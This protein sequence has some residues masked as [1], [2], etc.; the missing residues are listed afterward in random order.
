MAP[1]APFHSSASRALR[2]CTIAAHWWRS[3]FQAKIVTSKR[4]TVSYVSCGT[5]LRATLLLRAPSGKQAVARE[6]PIGTSAPLVCRVPESLLI[7]H[8]TQRDNLRKFP[9]LRLRI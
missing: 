1:G 5:Q 2:C 7:I 9:E 4:T 6:V 3:K 8:N